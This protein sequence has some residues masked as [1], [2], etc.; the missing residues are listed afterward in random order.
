[1]FVVPNCSIGLIHFHFD[2]LKS[3]YLFCLLSVAKFYVLLTVHLD[4]YV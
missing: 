4:T 3:V 1:M 2:V